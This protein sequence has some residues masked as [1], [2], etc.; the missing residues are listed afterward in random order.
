MSVLS[1]GRVW[2]ALFAAAVCV[3]SFFIVKNN[4]ALYYYDIA[5]LS[6]GVF[7]LVAFANAHNDI[8][9]FEIDKI[10]RPKRPLPSGRIS[11]GKA[12]AVA[13]I[14]FL[15]AVILGILADVKFALLFAAVGVFCFIYN[16][17]LK[18]LPLAGNFAVALL[19][20]TPIIIPI[21]K[22][23]LPQPELINLAFFAFTLTFA[24]EIAKDIEDM[25][26]DKALGLKTC[27]LLWGVSF[28]LIL[29][30]ICELLCLA[31]LA[32]FKPFLLLVIAPCLLLSM[33]FA[34]LKKW[35]FSQTT[36]KITMVAG[37][38]LYSQL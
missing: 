25:A 9:D 13:I 24:R 33:V 28:S 3:Y 6:L 11:F 38:L 12:Y 4:F 1:L 37:L 7:L 32:C 5:V 35:R 14:C 31:G 15:G 16:K 23:G 19:T 30:F 36:I 20:T 27:P 18:N 2:N 29:I 34:I 10:T 26:G 21:I 8:M 22:F 17:F